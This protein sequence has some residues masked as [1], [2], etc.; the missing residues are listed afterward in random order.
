MF[1]CRIL[2]N[3]HFL[4]KISLLSYKD[5]NF[6][7]TRMELNYFVLNWMWQSPP[8][9]L[10]F[11]PF[12]RILIDPSK[13]SQEFPIAVM[14]LNIRN[15]NFRYLFTNFSLVN[16]KISAIVEPLLLATIGHFFLLWIFLTNTRMLTASFLFTIDWSINFNTV[17]KIASSKIKRDKIKITF[18]R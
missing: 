18:V 4:N 8:G 2:Q 5:L 7:L 14:L 17:S 3:I 9:F 12:T 13:Q 11:Y 10:A 16:I 6:A 15:Y 1:F